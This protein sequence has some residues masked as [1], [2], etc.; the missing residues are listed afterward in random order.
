MS[1]EVIW[2][3]EKYLRYSDVQSRAFEDLASRVDARDPR[4]VVD[5]GCG[6]GD[7]TAALSQ[8]WPLAV[9]TGIDSSATMVAKAR[10][11]GVRAELGDM[12][13]WRPSAETDV[14]LCHTAIHWVPEHPQLIASWLNDLPGGSWFG[15]CSPDDAGDGIHALMEEVADRP[16]WRELVS[17]CVL[18]L[19]EVMRPPDVYY[20]LLEQQGFRPDVWQS[21]H[22]RCLHGE[23]TLLHDLEAAPLRPIRAKLD[24]EQWEEFRAEFASELRREYPRR[25]D[26]TTRFATRMLFVVGHR[27]ENA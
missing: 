18:R 16:H 13:E 4:Q 25:A 9:V 24:D 14:V 6:P 20:S 11:H 27:L 1:S 22:W 26:G 23:D 2:N 19:G 10:Q 5:L 21:R 17:D 15:M 12:R 3:T 8:R 7:L